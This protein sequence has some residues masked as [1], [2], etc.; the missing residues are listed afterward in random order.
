[1]P[2]EYSGSQDVSFVLLVIEVKVPSASFR[3]DASNQV[4][5]DIFTQI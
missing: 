5:R 1:M 3:V 4:V 2:E